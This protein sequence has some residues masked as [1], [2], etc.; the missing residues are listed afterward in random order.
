MS[1]PVAGCTDI[2][3]VSIDGVRGA[4]EAMVEGK[5]NCTVDCN[6][7]LAPELFD[8]IEKVAARQEVAKRVVVDAEVFEQKQ[9]K[10]ELPNRKY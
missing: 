10:D 3:I 8:A 4:F 1:L 5:L 7:L 9:A 6:P 2:L